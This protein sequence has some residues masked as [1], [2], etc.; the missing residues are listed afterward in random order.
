MA[1]EKYRAS[2]K[3]APKAAA[4]SPAKSQK[5]AQNVKK[6]LSSEEKMRLAK[7]KEAAKRR[8]EERARQASLRRERRRR[9]FRLCFLISLVFVALYWVYVAASI[10][11][12]PDGTEDELPVMLF[13]EGE[14]KEDKT[15]PVEEVT[16]GGVK[17]IP[18][19]ELSSYI[20]ISQ[21]GDYETRSFLLPQSGEYATFFVGTPEVIINGNHTAMKEPALLIEDQ[22]YLPSDFFTKTNFFTFSSNVSA[23]GAD[24]L[25]YLGTTGEDSFIFHENTTSDPVDFATVPVAP[26][27]PAEE[28]EAQEETQSDS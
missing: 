25:T 28:E 2:V 13:T 12:R 9:L 14:R 18:L 23:Y 7:K 6:A 24:V 27:L 22:L 3:N 4:K 19:K 5:P 17:Y 8:R 10:I 11:G 20:A 1:Q 26:T 21:F 15:L 16:I